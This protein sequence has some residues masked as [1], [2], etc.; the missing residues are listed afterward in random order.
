MADRKLE[1]N[2]FPHKLYVEKYSGKDG[3][4]CHMTLRKWL[5]THTHEVVANSDPM[6]LDLFYQQVNLFSFSPFFFYAYVYIR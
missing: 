6:T 3:G 4:G 5:F 1:K 2:E